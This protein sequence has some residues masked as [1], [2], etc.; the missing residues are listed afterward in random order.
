MAPMSSNN[1]VPSLAP[2]HHSVLLGLAR[3]SI[4]HGLRHHR[5]PVVDLDGYAPELG[6][7]RASFV[8]LQLDSQ[9]RGCIG[10]LEAHR[11]LVVDVAHNAFAAAFRDL[12]FPPVDENEFARLELHISLLTPAVPLV[13]E[14]EAD[15]LARIVPGEDGL[16]LADGPC[17]GT[18]LPAVWESLPDPAQFLEHLKLKAGLPRGYRSDT[19]RV[20]RYRTEVIG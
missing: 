7:P 13:F 14:S 3:E 20:W 8:T 19:L 12:R 5:P 2:A 10:S 4:R 16:I 18:F 9:L 17:R 1:P 11:P 15:L 6:Q